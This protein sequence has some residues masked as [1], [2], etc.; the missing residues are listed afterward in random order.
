MGFLQAALLASCSFFLGVSMSTA[1][2]PNLL[3]CS[4]PLGV[5]FMCLN[6]DYRILWIDLTDENIESA[7]TFYATFRNAPA[8]VRVRTSFSIFNFFF[9]LDFLFPSQTLVHSMMG[10]GLLALA[11]KLWKWDESAMFFDG[12]SLGLSKSTIQLSSSKLLYF[13]RV[14]LCGHNI[15]HRDGPRVANGR[16]AS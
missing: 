5:L 11:G 16:Y 10:V 6:I 9:E 8:A 13:S 2:L 14:S 4:P 7:Y 12:S 1:A 15:F 3:G